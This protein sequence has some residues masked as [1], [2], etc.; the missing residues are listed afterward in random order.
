MNCYNS[1]RFLREALQS[2]LDQTF[3]HWEIIFWDNRST[4]TSAAIVKSFTDDRI[5]YFYA[6]EHT[7]LGEARNFALLKCSG[8]FVAFLDCD[9]IWLPGKLEQQVR[10]MEDQPDINLLYANYYQLDMET[11][12]RKLWLRGKQPEGNIFE[13]FLD[14][15]TKYAI[16]ILTVLIR[17][18]A[19]SRLKTLFDE[20]LSLAEDY[21][22]FMRILAGSHAGYLPE[23]VAVY[24][25][26][27]NM[28]SYALRDGWVS[29]YTYIVE[30]FKELDLDNTYAKALGR[31]EIQIRYVETTID[32]VK[33]HLENA[34]RTITPYKYVSLRFYLVY[35]ATF[36]PLTIWFLLR[37][38]WGRGVYTR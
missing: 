24:R 37:P 18:Q 27:P 25:V 36:I 10:I 28:T 35:L 23:P 21:D 33:G 16:G 26:H 11:N 8:E 3:P 13:E 2:V 30:K 31:M 12:R 32:M 1:D 29:E 5:K 38:L 34:R 17:R 15:N 22:L 6:P 20:N 19:F 4:D 14:F 7:G 9:D